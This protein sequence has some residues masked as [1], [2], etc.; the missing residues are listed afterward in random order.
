MGHILRCKLIPKDQVHPE[1]WVGA[2]RK[3]RVVPRDRLARVEHNKVSKF[4]YTSMF[5]FKL[6]I[7]CPAS[8]RIAADESYQTSVETT[9]R[10]Q[11]QAGAGGYQI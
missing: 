6:G 7:R 5:C 2:N 3:W 1:L 4:L 11:A 9:K 10:A 8:Y